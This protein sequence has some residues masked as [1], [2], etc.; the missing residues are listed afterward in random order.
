MRH[1]ICILVLFI[2]ITLYSQWNLRNSGTSEKLND[3]FFPTQTTGYAVGK[4]GLILKT[5]NAGE[6]WIHLVS[7]TPRGLAAVYFSSETTGYVTGEQGVI[8]KTTDGG[9]TWQV[10]ETGIAGDQ[11]AV[12]FLNSTV[13]FAGEAGPYLLSTS[14]TGVTWNMRSSGIGWITDFCFPDAYTGYF[15]GGSS[16][17]EIY[18]TTDGGAT[19]RSKT[20]TQRPS[21]LTSVFFID[22]NTG[23]AVRDAGTIL[24][25][26]DGGDTWMQMNTIQYS[27]RSVYF[28]YASNGY[29]A[30]L[31]GIIL[32]TNNGGITWKVQNTGISNRRNLYSIFFTGPNTGYAVGDSGT[33]LKT[34]NGGSNG[35]DESPSPRHGIKVFPVPAVDHIM[36]ELTEGP[37]PGII[38]LLNTS[39]TILSTQQAAE[40][41]TTIDLSNLPRGVYFVRFANDRNIEVE[42]VLKEKNLCESDRT[43]AGS[44]PGRRSA[45]AGYFI[46]SN[47]FFSSRYIL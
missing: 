5:T 6:T 13:R 27:C 25:T 20:P 42:K 12:G 21:Y 22:Q 43:G 18:K 10:T 4:G 45:G 24:R 47:F 9:V 33:I 34:I 15:V 31:A 44:V 36:V 16:G 1:F 2:P 30:C 23:F 7:G 38:T 11:V 35:V 17:G 28:P 26:A 3:I 32:K 40:S 29:I 8:L 37:S 14:D 46:L 41:V 19:W 39:G